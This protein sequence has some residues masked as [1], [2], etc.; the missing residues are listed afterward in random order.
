MSSC[1]AYVAR[2][3]G[4]F[5]G[6]VFVSEPIKLFCDTDIGDDDALAIT[7][8]LRAP[9]IELV[10]FSTVAGN[11]TVENATRNL[12]TLL[13]VAGRTIPVTLGAARPLMVAPSHQGA[14]IHGP[15]GFWNTQQ[16]H[17]LADIPR[18]APRAIADAAR[19]HPGMTLL[20]L[21]PLTNVARA[22]QQYP[23][24]LATST[25]VALFGGKRG[26]ITPLA[27]FNAWFDPDA[28]STV[29]KFGGNLT[30]IT[31]DAWSPITVEPRAL[32]EQL[33]QSA[34]PLAHL[35]ASPLSGY[36]AAQLMFGGQRI[37]IP[38]ALAAAY[39]I[40]PSI[41][42]PQPALVKVPNDSGGITRGLTV[43]GIT[44]GEKIAMIGSD[45]ELSAIVDHMYGDPSFNL[46]AAMAGILGREP[47]NARVVLSLRP[48][49]LDEAIDRL[50]RAE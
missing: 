27:E 22:I 21:G 32:T 31:L 30:M 34:D 5:S 14:A 48:T 46:P 42:T 19:A 23:D 17:D 10:G 41:G 25:I 44:P 20:A 7:L 1:R 36:A 2:N 28:V 12:L 13:D 4:D 24:L 37:T 49:A 39:V 9:T 8:L 38:D 43:I 45:T 33:R 18:D 47:D 6:E 26:N 15:D 29:L 16:P 3:T 50:C 40:D 35:L 11:T